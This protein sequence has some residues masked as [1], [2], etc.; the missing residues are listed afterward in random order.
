MLKYGPPMS[1]SDDSDSD[2]LYE[3]FSFG[4]KL[5]RKRTVYRP[6]N[7]DQ[8]LYDAIT[9][10]DLERTINEITALNFDCNDLI[11]NETTPLHLACRVACLDIVKYLIANNAN[12]N[13]QVDSITPLMEVCRC[14][15]KNLKDISHLIK[16]VTLLLEKGAVINIS[17]KYGMTPFLFACESG[18]LSI[19]HELLPHVSLEAHNNEG[20]TA[21][22]IAIENNRKEVVKFLIESGV[23]CNIVDNK[24]YTPCQF[25]QNFGF[26]DILEI[27]PKEEIPYSIPS[28]FLTYNCLRDH[29]PR[30]FLKSEVPE[31]FQEIYAILRDIKMERFAEYFALANINLAEFLTLTDS[32]M[33]DIGI[34]FPYQRKRIRM[35]LLY[36]HL[37]HWSKKSIARVK[38][39]EN[40]NFYDI[41]MLSANHLLN[42]V[43]L[44]AALKFVIQNL[45]EQCFG[46]VSHCEASKMKESLSRYQNILKQLTKTTKYLHSFSPDKPPTYIDYDEYLFK[47]QKSNKLKCCIKYSILIGVS[48]ILCIKFKPF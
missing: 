15:I 34:L 47:K 6:V 37:H 25:A 40:D 9:S 42:L 8:N 43:I 38:R 41:L 3:G 48:I 39:K 27:L 31:Y 28:A 17:D 24:G 11:L 20:K 5:S 35:G 46:N 23:N 1:D 19:L 22:F 44:N 30:I 21:I 18:H 12:V 4:D 32:Q 2:D 16:I 33:K 36:F 26:D 29:I 10:G 7:P 14:N 45:K 13:R